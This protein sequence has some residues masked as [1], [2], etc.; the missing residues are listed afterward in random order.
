MINLTEKQTKIAKEVIP[1]IEELVKDESNTSYIFEKLY[2]FVSF[3]IA[4]NKATNGNDPT[5]FGREVEEVMDYVNAAY[6]SKF[7]FNGK[8]CE[9]FKCIEI[10][11]KGTFVTGNEYKGVHIGGSDPK[12]SIIDNNNEIYPFYD[13]VFNKCFIKI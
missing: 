4:D 11:P 3:D 8:N 7:L 12:T 2:D 10:P 6:E 1:N 9:Q 13:D 5:E